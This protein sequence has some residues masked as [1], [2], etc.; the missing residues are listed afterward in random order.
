MKN[1]EIIKETISEVLKRMN[2]TG[3]ISVEDEE[4]SIIANIYTN[5]AN[6]LIG[7]SGA[8]LNA[9]QYICRIITTKK[10]Q[11]PIQFILDVNNYRKQR[12]ESLKELA[13]KVAKQTVIERVAI[14][15][16][17]MSSY[18]RRVIHLTLFNNPEIK[19]ESVGEGVERRIV[20][21]PVE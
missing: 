19:T 7:Q 17:P 16:R 11:E 12:T 2:F 9:L 20:V 3:D 21:K 8:N 5:E 10:I 1:K 6:F 4:E 13:V 15:L 18:E 14:T